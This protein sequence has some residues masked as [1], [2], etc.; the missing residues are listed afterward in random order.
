MWTCLVTPSLEHTIRLFLASSQ[1][2]LHPLVIKWQDP[3]RV[4]SLVRSEIEAE[5]ERCVSD[6]L[7]QS[8][9]GHCQVP[10][11]RAEDYKNKI[12]EYAGHTFLVGIRFKN[13]NLD[14]AFVEIMRATISVNEFE[15]WEGL[16]EAAFSQYKVFHPKA[17]RV[18]SSRIL[19]NF[20]ADKSIYAARISELELETN[21]G[22]SLSFLGSNADDLDYQRYRE[23][24]QQLY[25]SHSN[26]S[27]F[28][29]IEDQEDLKASAEDGLMFK[30]EENGNPIAFIAGQRDRLKGL[31]G[32]LI[33]E[34]VVAPEAQGRGCGS[35]I[36]RLFLEAVGSRFNLVF[37]TI[38]AENKAPIRTAESTG[39]VLVGAYYW[40]DS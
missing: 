6:E 2:E 36:Q 13:L 33:T 10:G 4:Q 27:A 9:Y 15:D 21:L 40:L 26:L 30:L 24:Y 18:F 20:R 19:P 23:I 29:R 37:G 22:P 17:I 34:I 16:K 11:S 14:E 35:T 12:V 39:R 3:Q 25:R 8:F 28:A 31:E 1:R 7:A 38:A 32:L 5:Y